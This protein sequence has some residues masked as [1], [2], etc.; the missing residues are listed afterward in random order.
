MSDLQA[1]DE[2]QKIALDYLKQERRQFK[3]TNLL[4]F[5]EMTEF[6]NQHN[7]VL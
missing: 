2:E 1:M 5:I 3:L 6:I 7:E 4:R